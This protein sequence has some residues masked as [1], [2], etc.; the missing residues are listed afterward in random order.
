MQIDNVDKY[1]YETEK[2]IRKYVKNPDAFTEI[3]NRAY[4]AVACA[5]REVWEEN[6]TQNDIY[7][8]TDFVDEM[9]VVVK[10]STDNNKIARLTARVQELETL[11]KDEEETYYSAWKCGW[12][13]AR[14]P[15][16]AE[17]TEHA[18][19][20]ETHPLVQ[21]VKELED[22]NRW[23]SVK[24]RLP[25]IDDTILNTECRFSIDVMIADEDTILIHCWY[26]YGNNHW[27][28][29]QFDR[30]NDEP[31]HWRPMPELPEN[32]PLPDVPQEGE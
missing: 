25:G 11:L 23:V 4:E 7:N 8:G 21:R 1:M 27:Y 29:A 3:Y 16:P 18:L 12:C 30:L 15:T 10:T 32:L 2:A 24:E 9:S 19:T 17:A 14:F 13:N 26:D 5:M 22:A 28:S 20:C 6:H 31:T